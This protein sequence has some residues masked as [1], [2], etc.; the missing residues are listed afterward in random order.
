MGSSSFGIY[1]HGYDFPAEAFEGPPDTPC[2]CKEL[3]EPR[4]LCMR[5]ETVGHCRPR[6][7]MSQVK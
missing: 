2:A 1:V 3:E 5:H 7:I 6:H 4:H